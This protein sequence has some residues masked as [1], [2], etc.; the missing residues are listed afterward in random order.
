M[1]GGMRTRLVLYWK[2]AEGAPGVTTT[3][4][5]CYG[6]RARLFADRS[7]VRVLLE[8]PILDAKRGFDCTPLGI[9]N[10]GA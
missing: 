8:E 6:Q 5:W 3:Q 4:M 10:L 7:A 1:L 2:Y 9:Y